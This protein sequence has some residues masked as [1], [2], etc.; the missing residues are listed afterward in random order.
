MTLTMIAALVGCGS[1]TDQYSHDHFDAGVLNSG[2]N[3]SNVDPSNE[4]GYSRISTR[5][6]DS[7]EEGVVDRQHHEVIQSS[8][9][10]L[11]IDITGKLALVQFERKFLFV[12]LDRGF[13]SSYDLGGVIGFQYAEP[14]Q[15]GLALV[16][17]S[18]AR[19]FINSSFKQAFDSDFE[20]AE[21]FHHDRSLVKDHGQYRII[22]TNGKTVMDLKYDQVSPQSPFC[23]Q[24][25]RMDQEKYLSGFVDLNGNLV[26][27]LIYDYVGYFDAQVKR[28]LVGTKDRYGFMDEHAAIVIPLKYEYAEPFDRG[29]ARVAVDGRTFFVDR[30]GIEVPE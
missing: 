14:F 19:F 21:S 9:S 11:V 16:S 6:G 8:K 12:P 4:F 3:K 7:Y 2:F 27:E 10:L 29:K 13:V 28:I 26:S 25:T 1:S 23:W 5:I 15:C 18:D 22:D 24:V 20:F 30:D 17:V